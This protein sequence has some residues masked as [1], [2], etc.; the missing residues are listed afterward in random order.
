MFFK[1][2]ML[3]A[4]EKAMRSRELVN[5]YLKTRGKALGIPFCKINESGLAAAGAAVL[6]LEVF[7]NRK[8][9]RLLFQKK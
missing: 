3:P 7:H 5:V 2:E 1:C 9:G 8:G 4:Q 6:A